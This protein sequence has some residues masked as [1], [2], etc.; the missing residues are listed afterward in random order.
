MENRSAVRP[1]KVLTK[2]VHAVTTI[3][4]ATGWLEIVQLDGNTG[5]HLAQKLTHSGSVNT[6]VRARLFVIME[7]NSLEKS[8]KSSCVVTQLSTCQ[9]R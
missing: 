4:D 7:E 2:E 3:D 6:C 9:Q 8:S 1:R 5:A